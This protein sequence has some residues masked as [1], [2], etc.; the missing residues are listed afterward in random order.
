MKLRTTFGPLIITSKKKK[1]GCTGYA[2]LN[3]PLDLENNRQRTA[4]QRVSPGATEIIHRVTPPAKK[5]KT[6]LIN[7]IFTTPGWGPP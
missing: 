7:E 5:K 4:T 6:K 3:E 1:T 2:T